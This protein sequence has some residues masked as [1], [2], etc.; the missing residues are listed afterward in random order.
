LGEVD[1]PIDMGL[2]KGVVNIHMVD[3]VALEDGVGQ[4]ES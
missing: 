4:G 3:F 2:K 1:C